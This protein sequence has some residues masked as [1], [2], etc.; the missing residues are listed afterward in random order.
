MGIST[1]R[2]MLLAVIVLG[3]CQ[4]VFAAV[5]SLSDYPSD[6]GS[7]GEHGT[8]RLQLDVSESGHILGCKIVRPSGAPDLDRPACESA[9]L[10]SFAP[11]AQPGHRT[12]EL[13]IHYI[14]PNQ[15]ITDADLPISDHDLVVVFNPARDEAQRR[16]GV[17]GPGKAHPLARLGMRKPPVYPPAAKAAKHEGSVRAV[18][19]VSKDG[20]PVACN[21]VRSSGYFDL[22]EATCSYVMGSAR[23]EPGTDYYGERMTDY[24]LISMNWEMP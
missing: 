3:V 2:W 12:A 21:V 23:Y 24:D 19:E 17:T 16:Y 5:G 20:K 18:I 1:R 14:V 8:V 22:D 15:T 10:G 4:P 9:K 7:K 11:S 6:A 13:A